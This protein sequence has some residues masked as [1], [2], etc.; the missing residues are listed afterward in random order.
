MLRLGESEGSE[1]VVLSIIISACTAGFT[2]ASMSYDMDVNPEARK[3]SP[4]FYGYVPD[5]ASART[6]IFGC[7]FVNSALLI[8]IRSISIALVLL[9]KN[10]LWFVAYWLADMGLYFLWKLARGDFYY[11]MADSGLFVACVMRIGVKVVTDYSC[12]LQFRHPQE[13]GGIYFTM[14]IGMALLV[15]FAC[16]IIYSETNCDDSKDMDAAKCDSNKMFTVGEIG[17]VVGG[18]GAVW[19][20]VG[21]MFLLL[22]K[23]EYRGSF[24]SMETGREFGRNF[25]IYGGTDELKAEIFKRNDKLWMWS[26]GPR[27]K[28]WVL[29]SWWTWEEEKPAFFDDLFKASVPAHFVPEEA[30]A[31]VE[32]LANSTTRRRRRQTRKGTRGKE[33]WWGASSKIDPN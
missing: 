5:R 24:F 17:S 18:M 8:L 12:L 27:V 13:I 21:G 1:R 20:L 31:E 16:V 22:M 26:M 11:W 25:F 33:G 28:E 2:S 9:V 23:R 29:E 10:K 7:M 4:Q 30:T 19:L 6:L 15:S 3:T 32:S 14:N